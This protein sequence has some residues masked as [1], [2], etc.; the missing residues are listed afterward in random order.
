[1]SFSILEHIRHTV[2]ADDGWL[3]EQEKLPDMA[4]SYL[5]ISSIIVMVS[6]KISYLAGPT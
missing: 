6:W 5:I 2:F 4:A 1:M 3:G